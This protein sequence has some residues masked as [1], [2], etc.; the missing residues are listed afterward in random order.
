MPLSISQL[1]IG[2]PSL[3]SYAGVIGEIEVVLDDPS[4]TLANLGEVIEKD[5]D[6]TARLLKLGNSAFFGFPSRLETVAE[7]I[8]LIG[9]QQV[10]DLILASSVVEI[11]QGIPADFVSMESFW[12]HSLSCGIG[13]RC[14][15]VARQM[16]AAEKYFVAGLLHDLGRLVLLSRAPQQAGEV[17]HRYRRSRILLRDAENEILGFNHA[18]VGE[19]LLRHW[20]YPA[21]LVHAVAYH[22]QP[23]S[24][25]VYQLESSVVHV[26]DY[27]VHAMQMGNSGE[28]FVPP[29]NVKAWERLGLST[30]ILESV[31]KSID[32]QIEIVQES[33]IQ[34]ALKSP[35]GAA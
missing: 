9:I 13:A 6:L 35:K 5:P 8:S 1:I 29:L 3:G 2:I 23:I 19:A 14:L 27:L 7:A 10:K 22:H 11:F 31:T 18:Q 26:A 34:P 21:N 30:N 20:Q 17:F 32:E 12:K 25:G 28:R 15:A 4:S 16:P 33:L 24:G